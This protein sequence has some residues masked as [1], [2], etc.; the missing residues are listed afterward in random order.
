MRKKAELTN[1][2]GKTSL[3]KEVP[4][5]RKGKLKSEYLLFKNK[6]AEMENLMKIILWIIFF[7]IALLALYLLFRSFVW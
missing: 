2:L 6:K 3:I 5:P 4:F 1:F 7:G